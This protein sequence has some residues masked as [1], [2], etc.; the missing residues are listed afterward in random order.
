[1]H[2]MGGAR[3]WLDLVDYCHYMAPMNLLPPVPEIWGD[4]WRAEWLRRVAANEPWLFTWLAHP[5]DEAYWRLHRGLSEC[6]QPDSTNGL[7][8]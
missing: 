2:Q 3:K 6:H 8:Y 5:E 7:R 4:T 1:V